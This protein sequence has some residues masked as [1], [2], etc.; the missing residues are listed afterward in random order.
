M[1]GS[2]ASAFSWV[3]SKFR[4]K[5]VET[6]KDTTSPGF[7]YL[8]GMKLKLMVVGRTAGGWISDGCDQYARR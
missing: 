1:S 4:T 7:W 8:G 3:S 5:A 6:F 2:D